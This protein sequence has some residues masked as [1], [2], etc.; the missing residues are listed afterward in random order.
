MRHGSCIA[1]VSDVRAAAELIKALEGDEGT[2]SA[3]CLR[4]FEDLLR[5]AREA[6]QL[7]RK[8]AGENV[9]VALVRRGREELAEAALKVHNDKFEE[10]HRT[11][12][13]A[14]QQVQVSHGIAQSIIQEVGDQKQTVRNKK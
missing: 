13:A 10:L 6:L 5:G 1:H 3:G 11:M 12:V 2:R 7:G 8:T 9:R 14:E 4:D